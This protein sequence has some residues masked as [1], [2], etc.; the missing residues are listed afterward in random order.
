MSGQEEDPEEPDPQRLARAVEDRPC[1]HGRLVA[2]AP[3]LLEP[4]RRDDVARRLAAPWAREIPPASA[5]RAGSSSSSPR[6]ESAPGTRSACSERA[7]WL[8]PSGARVPFCRVNHGHRLRQSD[9]PVGRYR[10]S[11]ARFFVLPVSA[12]IPKTRCSSAA[13]R[14]RRARPRGS[15]R[16]VFVPGGPSFAPFVH[17]ASLVTPNGDNS[18]S[19]GS[20]VDRLPTGSLARSLGLR[21]RSLRPRPAESSAFAP[22]V[23]RS[24]RL[25]PG[26]RR[27]WWRTWWAR[28]GGGGSA[29]PGVR[30]ARIAPRAG[31]LRAVARPC[32]VVRPIDSIASPV[33]A[34]WSQ[35]DA[36]RELRLAVSDLIR[37]D[38]P[39]W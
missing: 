25:A 5:P 24:R 4:P 18:S 8:P 36:P 11:I 9:R 30:A 35:V 22:G 32:A 39:R 38:N 37:Y 13:Q 23:T 19:R 26:A 16:E 28:G 17:S 14:R 1:R 15:A 21:S 31:R 3:T 12:S 29:G 33:Q 6:P 10:L 34:P 27:P 20:S 2:T 7:S